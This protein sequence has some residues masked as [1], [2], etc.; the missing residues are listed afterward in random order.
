MLSPKREYQYSQLP[1]EP[2]VKPDLPDVSFGIDWSEL[3]ILNYIGCGVFGT[4][5]KAEISGERESVAV[6]IVADESRWCQVCC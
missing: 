5:W 1:Q 4:V 3:I 2:Y 6:K